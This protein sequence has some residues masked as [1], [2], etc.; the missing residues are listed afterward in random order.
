MSGFSVVI[1]ER[2]E[3][4]PNLLYLE[5]R[6]NTAAFV[7]RGKSTQPAQAIVG[8]DDRWYEHYWRVSLEESGP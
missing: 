2:G 1:L 6:S 5:S 7:N 3:D 4:I 8:S